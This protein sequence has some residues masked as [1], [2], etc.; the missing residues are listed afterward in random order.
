MRQ[1][2]LDDVRVRAV[3]QTLGPYGWRRLTPEM[4]SRR[5]LAAVDGHVAT[6]TMPVTR[7]DE[8]IEVLLEFLGCCSW[9][10][11][12]VDALS[13]RLVTALDTWRTESHWLEIELRWLLDAD[14]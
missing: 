5:A 13:R 3:I 14:D 8:R 6:G 9:R 12:T 2:S 4:V 10:T 7:H 1:A 11:L